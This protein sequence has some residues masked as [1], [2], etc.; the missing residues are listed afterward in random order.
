MRYILSI[1]Q[2]LFDAIQH[3]DALKRLFVLSLQMSALNSNNTFDGL[4]EPVR[5]TPGG[6]KRRL[7]KEN[8]KK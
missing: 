1:N 2:N 3:G 4:D 8:H 5:P 6:R 7:D